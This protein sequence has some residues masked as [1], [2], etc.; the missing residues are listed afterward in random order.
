MS[1]G[2]GQAAVNVDVDGTVSIPEVGFG[3]PEKGSLF[4]AVGAKKSF[5]SASM[6]LLVPQELAGGLQLPPRAHQSDPF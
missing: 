3:V 2:G 6:L 4:P 1:Q 5:C